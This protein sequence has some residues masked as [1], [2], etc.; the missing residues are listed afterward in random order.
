M[1]A[2]ASRSRT[3]AFRA[4]RRA[5]IAAARKD[6]ACFNE[7][8]LRDERTGQPVVLCKMHEFW[9]DAITV[10]DRLVVL[11]HVE[12]AK[13][14]EISV[15][16]VLF[17]LARDPSKRICILSN[18]HA[19]ATKVVR[20]IAQYIEGS[21]ELREV[22]PNLRRD[23]DGKW[24][25]HALTVVRPTIAKDPSVSAS[26]LAGDIVGSRFDLIVVDD[27]EDFE[28]SRTE[29]S[30]RKT[31]DWFLSSAVSRL[32]DGGKI[33]AVGTV[34]HRDDLLST[35]ARRPGW[36][37]YRFP[38]VDERTGEPNWPARWSH[39][40]IAQAREALGPF[41]AARALDLVPIAD[42]SA[43]IKQEWLAAAL[44]AGT[45]EKTH[46]S[47]RR[48]PEGFRISI[49]CDPAVSLKA[50]ADLTAVSVVGKH[51]DGR[52]Q[53]LQVRSGHW[54][55]ERTLAE[56]AELAHL[57]V[58]ATVVVETVAA[59]A[60]IVQQLRERYG[61]RAR[62]HKTQG[63]KRSLHYRAERLAHDLERG[64]WTIAANRMDGSPGLDGE[65]RALVNDMTVYSPQDHVGDRL[66]SLLIADSLFSE[67]QAGGAFIPAFNLAR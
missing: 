66:A 31:L 18:T 13:T 29:Q 24:A 42:E 12:A 52:K 50:D 65:I 25:E 4:A 43:P 36:R 59:Q 45:D 40:R 28:S 35:L 11:A 6:A 9:Q 30:R 48:P 1:A 26:G 61:I 8:V 7:Y 67:A 53:V 47:C 63:G 15:G 37:S 38:V 23:P 27:V 56:L 39:E 19:Q 10:H 5:R 49:G 44:R 33:V 51:E 32:T 54:T 3:D 20:T 58:G 62:E 14:S 22:A 46:R 16:R 64:L 55:L 2:P 41:D 17:E 60:W 57:F 34:W 21:P